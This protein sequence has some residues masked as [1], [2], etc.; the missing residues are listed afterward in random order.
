MHASSL[1][2]LIAPNSIP[3]LAEKHT[4]FLNSPISYIRTALLDQRYVPV[5]PSLSSDHRHVCML[6][7]P[8]DTA[9]FIILVKSMQDLLVH[10][11]TKEKKKKH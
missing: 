8:L 1:T 10:E 2:S 9:E 11:T 6:D 4:T 3:N 7:A 5:S